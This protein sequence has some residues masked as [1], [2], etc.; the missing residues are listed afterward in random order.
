[1]C[2]CIAGGQRTTSQGADVEEGLASD[3]GCEILTQGKVPGVCPGQTSAAVSMG[4]GT[5][6]CSGLEAHT[7]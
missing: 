2:V 6:R 5:G 4:G 7:L 3:N 1:M